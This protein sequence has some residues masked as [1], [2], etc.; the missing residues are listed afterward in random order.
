[1]NRLL[2]QALAILLFCVSSSVALANCVGYGSAA[3]AQQAENVS[4]GCGFSG[5][6]WHSDAAGH[7]G[8]CLLVGEGKASGET[9]IREEELAKCRPAEVMEPVE[10]MEP[11]DVMENDS[12]QATQCERS[13]IAEGKGTTNGRAQSAAHSSLGRP[14]AEMMNAGLTQCM[15]HGLGCTGANS[16]RTC[17]MSVECCAN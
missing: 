5:L 10:A 11:A 2:L 3:V 17:W 15:Y 6:R 9:T 1:M 4:L 12:A 13:E 16:E 7:A 8:F 14:R